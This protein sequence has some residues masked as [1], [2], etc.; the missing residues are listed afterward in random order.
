MSLSLKDQLIA[1]GLVKPTP[2]SPPG[3]KSTAK[4]IPVSARGEAKARTAHRSPA[5]ANLQ[6][7]D[8]PRSA[9]RP[10]PPQNKPSGEPSLAAL[11]KARELEEQRQKQA[12]VAQAEAKARAK[13]ERKQQV[14]GLLTTYAQATGASS[15]ATESTDAQV[16]R[17]FEY[18]RKIRRIYLSEAQRTALNAGELG[19]VQMDGRF[20]LLPIELVQQIQQLAPEFIALCGKSE[21]SATAESDY[22]DPKF[23]VPDDIVW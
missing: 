16:A 14:Q 3:S 20:S 6:R 1:A 8:P 9:P 5:N 2:D 22:Q 7:R 12:I 19:V 13:R 18:A 23:Q 17:H 11:Y 21:E 15:L 10:A 4:Q